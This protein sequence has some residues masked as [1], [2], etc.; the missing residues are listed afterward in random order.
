MVLE[1]K[2]IKKICNFYVSDYHL[3][4]MLLP[5]ISKKIDNEE[6]IT[7]ITEIDLESTLNVVIERINLDKDK[8]EK[9]K[10]IGWN[11]QNIENIIPN[12]NVILIGS[13][14]FINEKVF[15]LKERQVENLEIIA[16]YNYN[17]VKNDMKEIVSKYDGMLNT[18]GINKI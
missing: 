7:I 3:E 1:E 8:K 15:E 13:K 6:N 9:I 4:I 2:K 12:T 5:Y 16:C 10:K 18:L 14:K 17:E 11:I